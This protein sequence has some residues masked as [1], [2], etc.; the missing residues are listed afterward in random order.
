MQVIHSG[1]RVTNFVLAQRV[2]ASGPT[3]PA[4]TGRLGQWL[5]VNE[6][7]D[8]T[9]WGGPVLVLASIPGLPGYLDL[10]GSPIAAQG[11]VGTMFA[12]VPVNN[13]R[14][15]NDAEPLANGMLQVGHMVLRPAAT[16][17]NA[18]R[19][20]TRITIG[21]DGYAQWVRLPRAGKVTVADAGAWYLYRPTM[22]PLASG[23]TKAGAVTAPAGARL[24]VMG[25]PGTTVTVNVR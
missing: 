13:G 24:V 19:A 16:L 3:T 14:D 8:S 18:S 25:R 20:T 6:L 5:I 15:Q 22:E 12:Q 17:P 10:G 4:W 21:K 7:S 9:A 11:T 2:Y 23:P 1:D